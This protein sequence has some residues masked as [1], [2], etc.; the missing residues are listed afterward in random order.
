M[1]SDFESFEPDQKIKL[2][3]LTYLQNSESLVFTER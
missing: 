3:S 2:R 1:E